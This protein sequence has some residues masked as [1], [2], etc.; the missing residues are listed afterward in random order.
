MG[1]E[2][3]LVSASMDERLARYRRAL[4]SGS[5]LP[6]NSSVELSM[7]MQATDAAATMWAG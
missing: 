4:Y 2:A 7:C 1:D 3:P 5:E 6:S